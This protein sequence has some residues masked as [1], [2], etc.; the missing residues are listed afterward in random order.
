MAPKAEIVNFFD[1]A[2][3]PGCVVCLSKVEE[4]HYCMLSVEN[5]ILNIIFKLC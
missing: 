2:A 4:S 3:I 1:N 5:S